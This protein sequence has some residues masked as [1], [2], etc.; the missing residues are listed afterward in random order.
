MM[1]EGKRVEHPAI[2]EHRREFLSSLASLVY[3]PE[4]WLG[5]KESI[6]HHLVFFRLTRAGRV[7]QPSTWFEDGGRTTKERE[8]PVGKPR[9]IVLAPA[10]LDIRVTPHCPQPGAGSI[11][12]DSIECARDGKRPVGGYVSQL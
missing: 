7:D 2:V 5:S 1:R 9:E 8:L 4:S 3:K 10:P 12:E 6:D 11:N